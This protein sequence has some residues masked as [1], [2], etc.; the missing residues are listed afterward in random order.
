MVGTATGVVKLKDLFSKYCDVNFHT[1]ISTWCA[2][3][4]TH[5][6]RGGGM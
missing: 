3:R 6:C 2:P 4:K 1:C 5:N